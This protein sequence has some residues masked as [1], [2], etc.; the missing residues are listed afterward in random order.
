MYTNI[1]R[2]Y[3]ISRYVSLKYGD[4][5]TEEQLRQSITTIT[6]CI[7][8]KTIDRFAELVLQRFEDLAEPQLRL[9]NGYY[10]PTPNRPKRP[11]ESIGLASVEREKRENSTSE[12]LDAHNEESE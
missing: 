3:Q 10:V 5:V 12:T 11:N 1:D 9:E 8:P 6:R 4:K 7:N 2:C